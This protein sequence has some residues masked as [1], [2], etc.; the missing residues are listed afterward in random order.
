[1]SKENLPFQKYLHSKYH[2]KRFYPSWHVQYRP[3][4]KTLTSFECLQSKWQPF[5]IEVFGATSLEKKPV[6]GK[7]ENLAML[8]F[9]GEKYFLVKENGKPFLEVTNWGTLIHT[10]KI[11]QVKTKSKPKILPEFCQKV[12]FC[13]KGSY[14]HFNLKWLP[15]RLQTF[16]IGKAFF[17]WLVLDMPTSK[18]PFWMIF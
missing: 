3:N 12:P 15:F 1:M 18:K 17:V 11:Y 9:S 5:Q 6:I 7:I 14:K 10:S 8:S 13:Q 16:K 2:P 4:K